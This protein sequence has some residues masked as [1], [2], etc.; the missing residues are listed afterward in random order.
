MKVKENQMASLN[1]RKFLRSIVFVSI[2]L[3][4]LPIIP[5]K[6]IHI[7]EQREIFRLE[8][9]TGHFNNPLGY[10]A[11]SIDNFG[12]SADEVSERIEE[13]EANELT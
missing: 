3:G 6:P 13:I 2:G 9:R 5:R 1:R 12:I 7:I 4:I 10:V 8:E 11:V